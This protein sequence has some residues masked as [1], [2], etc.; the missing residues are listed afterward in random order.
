MTP[1]VTFSLFF[2]FFFI[3]LPCRVVK[4]FQLLPNSLSINHLNFLSWLTDVLTGLGLGLV[5]RI[6][7]VLGRAR[8]DLVLIVC[9][10]VAS[11]C[12]NAMYKP[13]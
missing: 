2:Q 10:V 6:V 3:D 9:L 5:H 4:A 1:F 13:H 11:D 8:A 7:V 12:S